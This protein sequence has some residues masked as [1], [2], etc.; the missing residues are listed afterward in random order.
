MKVLLNSRGGSLDSAYA[1]ALYLSAY[2]KHV[3]VY[4]P[5]IAMSASTLVAISANTIYMS[6]FGNLGPLDSQIRDPH[7]P[8]RWLSVLDCYQSFDYLRDFGG[9]HD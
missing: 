2:A 6:A 3:E 8:T 9:E 1:S 5:L 4:V 7:N